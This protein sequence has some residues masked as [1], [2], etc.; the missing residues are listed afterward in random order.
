MGFPENGQPSEVEP[1]GWIRARRAGP[2]QSP[3]HGVA[4]LRFRPFGHG[5]PLSWRRGRR[6]RPR[7]GP[8]CCRPC[9]RP[10][11]FAAAL[12]LPLYEAVTWQG[13]VVAAHEAESGTCKRFAKSPIRS[14]RFG[15]R[16]NFGDTNGGRARRAPTGAADAATAASQGCAGSGE[17]TAHIAE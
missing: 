10:S 17:P 13:W 12:F 6:L 11:C 2:L 16:H 1:G 4:E 7:T 8:E 15:R 9:G 5:I 3:Q 14:N